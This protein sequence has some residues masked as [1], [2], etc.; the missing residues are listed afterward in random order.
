MAEGLVQF[1]SQGNVKS[2]KLFWTVE[3]NNA[4]PLLSF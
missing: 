4:H 3:H 1:C 2:I